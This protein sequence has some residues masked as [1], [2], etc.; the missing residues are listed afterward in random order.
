MK[1]KTLQTVFR[2]YPYLFTLLLLGGGLAV[3]Y[4][5]QANLFEERVI[6]GNLRV[7]LPLMI[8]A[9]GQTFVIIGGGIDLSVGAMVSMCNAILATRILQ[10]A[11]TANIFQNIA[12]VFLA[13][14]GAGTF[15][16]LCITYLRLQP[17]VT[18]YATSFVFAGIALY[19]LPE[20][21]GR[22]PRM[23]TS[24]YRTPYEGIPIPAFVMLGLVLVWTL[25]SATRFKQYLYALGGK[26]EA[27]Y[28]TGVPV[29]Q[30]R[31]LSYML[32]GVCAAGAATAL[33][34]GIGTGNPRIGDPLTLDSIVA[35]VLGGTRLSGGQGG[36]IGT[37]LGVFVLGTIRNIL[38]FG[39]IPTWS[40]TLVD[41]LIILGSLALPGLV[42][43]L[44]S[45]KA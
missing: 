9:I 33:T 32:S 27:A 6:N 5:L 20:P 19:I 34:M 30:M 7:F 45:K 28:T 22:L 40:K 13:G 2:K 18:T 24:F 21:G 10:D 31:L 8:V 16:G 36:I 26:A 41:A 37:M 42:R 12:L 35:V 43:L 14:L 25:M 23:A 3:N 1:L 17:I 38:S 44:G 39:D 15:N 29:N 4:Y 11:T